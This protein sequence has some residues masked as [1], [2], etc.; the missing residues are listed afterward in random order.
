MDSSAVRS[1]ALLACTSA[2]HCIPH[3]RPRHAARR[4]LPMA[5][6]DAETFMSGEFWTALSTEAR[7]HAGT[8]GLTVKSMR[9][10]GG[11]L[12]VSATGAGIDELSALGSRLSSFIDNVPP[13][14]IEEL[15]SFSLEVG[16]PGLG[17]LLETDLD[18]ATFKGFPVL[19][20]TSEPFKSKTEWEGTLVGRDDEFLSLNLKGRPVKIPIGIVVEVALPTA[21]REGGDTFGQ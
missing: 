5:A 21:K 11:K 18:F 10:E 16:S 9:F 6:L 15:P 13:E 17:S 7:T 19:A 12:K 2:L 20:T 4:A 1:L 14:Q 3:L 8:L